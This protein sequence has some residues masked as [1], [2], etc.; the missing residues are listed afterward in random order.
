M[1]PSGS[2]NRVLMVVASAV[3]LAVAVAACG[4]GDH[5]QSQTSRDTLSASS[6][7]GAVR[8]LPCQE[9]IGTGPP[10]SGMHVV[11]G[12]VALPASPWTRRALQTARS[13][14]RDPR[15]RLFAKQ[16]LVIRAGAR[17]RLIVAGRLRDRLSIGWGNAGEG[18]RGTTIAVKACSGPRGAKWLAYAGGYFVRDPMC[19]PLIVA[20]NGQQQ[21]VQIGIGKAC[22]GQRPP[23]QPTSA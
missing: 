8:V 10:V 2:Q 1:H 21:R 9:L 4:G 22:E 19:A 3:V 23:P 12:V 17:F 16:G 13:G 20:A 18:H 6:D 7:G 5:R 11:L 14:L 15:A